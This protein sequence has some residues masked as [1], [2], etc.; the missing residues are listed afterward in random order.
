MLSPAW[1]HLR[2]VVSR[3][4]L[5]QWPEEMGGFEGSSLG[6]YSDFARRQKYKEEFNDAKANENAML[7]IW[8]EA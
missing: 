1:C 2:S 8:M 7:G 4:Q 5:A 3:F 6:P